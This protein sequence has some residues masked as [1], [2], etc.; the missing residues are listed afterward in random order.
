MN[1]NDLINAMNGR[2]TNS[3]RKLSTLKNNM[4]RIGKGFESSFMHAKA[5]FLKGVISKDE[6]IVAIYE[7]LGYVKTRRKMGPYL[8]SENHVNGFE[9]QLKKAVRD[10][11]SP[12]HEVKDES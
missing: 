8:P 6:Y 7:G 10:L 5:D 2:P 12:E 4:Y 3:D 11:E 9:G 1:P